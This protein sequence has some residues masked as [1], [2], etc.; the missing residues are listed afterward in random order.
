MAIKRGA[1]IAME[2]FLFLNEYELRM[3]DDDI[4]E[5]FEKRGSDEISQ[6][7]FVGAIATHGHRSTTEED[8]PS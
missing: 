6:G 4:A 2:A 8:G 5:L 1:A 3:S 7:E